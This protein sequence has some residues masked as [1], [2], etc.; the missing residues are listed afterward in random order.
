ML[1]IGY[2]W[3]RYT[4]ARYTVPGMISVG[5]D[6]DGRNLVVGRAFHHGDML[7]AKVKPEHG[8]AYVCHAGQEHMKHDFE[9]LMP[10]EFKWVH[11]ANGYVPEGS[12]EGGRTMNGET[13]YIGRTYHN[14]VPCSG[15]IQRSHGV[16]Y[17]PYEG[18]EIPCKNYEVLVQN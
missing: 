9:I 2:K 5:S 6:L 7:P 13:L 1:I 14:G 16:L 12:V 3:V 4:G 8:V 18:K 11:A 17:I 10:A 15:K